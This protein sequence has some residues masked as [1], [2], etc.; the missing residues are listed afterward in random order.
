MVQFFNY[1]PIHMHLGQL[2][3]TRYTHYVGESPSF[4][5]QSKQFGHTSA[6]ACAGKVGRCMS[7]CA[8]GLTLEESLILDTLLMQC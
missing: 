3:N 4:R 1:Q 2:H 5:A 6:H 8:L 7:D